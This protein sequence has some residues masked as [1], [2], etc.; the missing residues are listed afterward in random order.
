MAGDELPEVGVDARSK[1]ASKRYVS[2]C[3]PPIY[4]VELTVFML[5]CTGIIRRV[6]AVEGAIWVVV[7]VIPHLDCSDMLGQLLFE[8]K[9][10]DLLRFA[11][12][13]KL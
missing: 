12:M 4:L 5:C 10:H 6:G 2:V 1:P 8:S 13:D 9:D 11:H 3:P 7:L